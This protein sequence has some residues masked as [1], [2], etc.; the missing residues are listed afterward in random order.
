MNAADYT[1]LQSLIFTMLYFPLRSIVSA[2]LLTLFVF[3]TKFGKSRRIYQLP[4]TSKQAKNEIV[5][6]L[7]IAVLDSIGVGLV[8]YTGLFRQTPGNFFNV[9]LTILVIFFWVE[10]I[11]YWFH[12]LVHTKKW[13]WIHRQHHV[14]VICWPVTFMSFSLTE[15]TIHGVLGI[16]TFALL[17]LY[18]P[19]PL[20]GIIGYQILFVLLDL[21]GHLNVEIFPKNFPKTWLGKIIFTPTYHA[22]H[23]A[24]YHGNY[25]L[26]SPF[27]DKFFGTQFS[28]YEKIQED[29][30]DGKS[31]TSLKQNQEA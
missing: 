18:I 19:I 22:L 20:E 25:G 30:A 6:A 10:F 26:F 8:H 13:Y 27:M 14:A 17:S 11:Y 15:R 24:R 28:D 16:G 29:V 5:A 21:V 1:P 31:L 9:T 3:K 4:I 23:H 12:R 7:K 2:G